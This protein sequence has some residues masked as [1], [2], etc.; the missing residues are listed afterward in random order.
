MNPPERRGSPW[1]RAGVGFSQGWQIL[2]E[3]L[4]II[5]L[6]AF[7]GYKLDEWLGTKPW[8]LASLMIVGYAGGVLHVVVWVRKRTEDDERDV[9]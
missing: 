5:A 6:F 1:S 3:L 7:G 8:F 4:A 9:R 2:V